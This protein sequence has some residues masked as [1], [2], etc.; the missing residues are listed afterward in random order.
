MEAEDSDRLHRVHQALRAYGESY[1]HMGK[2]FAASGGLYSTDAAAMLEILQAEEAGNPL[3]PARLGER[4]GLS[5]GATSTL[6]NRLEDAGHIVRNRGHADR[7]AV[8]LHSTRGIHA[9]AEAFF[10]PLEAR[11]NAV[12]ASRSGDDLD[13]FTRLL[14][15]LQ[16]TL[17]SY[18][19]E[20]DPPA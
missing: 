2:A 11:I 19:A 6:L 20:Q 13:E 1:L 3:S 14:E 16:Q 4:I 5:S 7:R 15:Q 9:T 12:L 10:G 8:T 18:R 17:D